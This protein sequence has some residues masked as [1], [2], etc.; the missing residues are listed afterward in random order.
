MLVCGV[1]EYHAAQADLGDGMLLIEPP[2][3]PWWLL[4]GVGCQSGKSIMPL[5]LWVLIEPLVMP[6]APRKSGPALSA[7]LFQDAA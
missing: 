5:R 4:G 7:F 1:I 6:T 2:V 3:M